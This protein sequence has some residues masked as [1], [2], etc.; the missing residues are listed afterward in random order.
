M[1]KP[2]DILIFTDGYSFSA[3]STFIKKVQLNGGAIIIGYRGNPNLN[4]FDS[5]QS[6]SSV[7]STEDSKD[8]L[9]KQITNLG[10]SLRY[11]IKEYFNKKDIKDEL[12]IPLEF[13]IN[14]IDEIF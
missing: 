1:R 6:P 10:F 9:S 2:T 13:K 12:N 3:R 4:K 5:S 14:E 8:D 11:I 7:F